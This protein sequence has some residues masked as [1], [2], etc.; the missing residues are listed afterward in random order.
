MS[1]EQNPRNR[2]DGGPIPNGEIDGLDKIG[3]VEE[4]SG[5][6]E[7][8][9]GVAAGEGEVV[10]GDGDG[11]VVGVVVR[12]GAADEDLD[13]A[14]ESEVKKE[15]EEEGD[16]ERAEVRGR[17]EE[18][19]EGEGEDEAEVGG[20]LEEEEEGVW[21]E[22]FGESVEVEGQSTVEVYKAAEERRRGG[23]GGGCG[24]CGFGR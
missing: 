22:R 16:E 14:D 7:D 23:G 3:V 5:D 19:G 24:D 8:P 18:E 9:G 11:H 21:E 15:A 17:G 20:V 6:E 10:G 4:G 12:A 13:E 2:G 1:A